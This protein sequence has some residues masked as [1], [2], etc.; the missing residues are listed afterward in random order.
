MQKK[1]FSLVV[2]V[3]VLT[4]LSYADVWVVHKDGVVYSLSEMNDAVVPSGYKV[5]ILKGGIED[6]ALSRPLDE[7]K[8]NG[9]KFT[10]D[11]SKIKAKED[12]QLA[13]EQAKT[14]KVQKKQSA[15]NKLKA[16]GLDES[17]ISALIGKE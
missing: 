1:I 3:F 13:L 16:V 8:F 15:I 12:A 2:A 10:V 17:E 11:A 9:K 6:L 14:L 7:Y 5:E 4:G